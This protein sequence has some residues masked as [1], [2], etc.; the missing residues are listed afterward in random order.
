M[1]IEKTRKHA[2][3]MERIKEDIT[4]CLQ[5]TNKNIEECH[6]EMFDNYQY[7]FRW[8]ASVLYRCEIKKEY[9]NQLLKEINNGDL[10]TLQIYLTNMVSTLTQELIE[11]KI[12]SSCIGG[13]SHV[14]AV[15][16]FEAKQDL[17]DKYT[18]IACNIDI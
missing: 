6:D 1:K 9:Y 12:D 15:L 2:E 11:G 10:E 8:Y 17:L 13:M 7:F 4:S 14:S 18:E 3:Q 16:E 5:I